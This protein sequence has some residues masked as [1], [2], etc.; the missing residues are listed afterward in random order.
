ME[1]SPAAGTD[2]AATPTQRARRQRIVQA[3][4]E[5]LDEREYDRIQVR[6]VA[7]AA[8]VAL[9]TLYRYF[10]S[11]EQLFAEALL[12]WSRSFETTVRRGRNASSDAERLG[13]LLRRAV[14]AF[15]RHPH[16]FQLIAVLEVANDEAVAATFRSYS[17]RFNT[18]L[19]D[20]LPDLEPADALVITELTSALLGSLLRA[21]SLDRLPIRDVYERLDRTV[22]IVFG[23]PRT[24]P[25]GLEQN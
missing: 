22:D 12:E 6:D 8:Q 3:A 15:E 14:A 21:W 10:P 18:V 13:M 24:R 25:T 17:A 4:I 2:L 20:A 7:E 1:P 11:K 5:L 19:A 16:F 9:G 23:A